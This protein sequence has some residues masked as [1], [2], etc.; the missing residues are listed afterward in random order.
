MKFTIVRFAFVRPP[1]QAKTAHCVLGLLETS[2]TEITLQ[3][4]RII[5]TNE[6]GMTY[7]PRSVSSRG[8]LRH[9]GAQM[10]KSEVRTAVCE[11]ALKLRVKVESLP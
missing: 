11:L 1:R 6:R 10:A 5:R 8:L 3:T 9:A 2:G 7:P 4:M